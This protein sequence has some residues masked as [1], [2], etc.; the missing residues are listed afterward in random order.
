MSTLALFVLEGVNFFNW[1]AGRGEKKEQM[2][3]GVVLFEEGNIILNI[4]IKGGD[5]TREAIN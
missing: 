5:Y 2:T 4:S 3:K 1:T